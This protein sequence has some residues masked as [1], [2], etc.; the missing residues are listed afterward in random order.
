MPHIQIIGSV[1]PRL[2][3]NPEDINLPSG[4]SNTGGLITTQELKDTDSGVA[5]NFCAP[6]DQSGRIGETMHSLG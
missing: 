6:V 3:K 5:A 2:L 1:I 4:R